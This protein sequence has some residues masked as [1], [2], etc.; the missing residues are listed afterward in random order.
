MRERLTPWRPGWARASGGRGPPG[1][2]V[3]QTLVAEVYGPDPDR[4][5]RLAREVKTLF[6]GTPA[7]RMWTG[8]SRMRS[9]PSTSRSISIERPPRCG[10]GRGLRSR[11]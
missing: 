6:D 10:T 5:S 3:L 4:R 9:R 2:P 1:P 11:V 8:T 7:S